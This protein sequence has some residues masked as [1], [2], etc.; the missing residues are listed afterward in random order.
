MTNTGATLEGRVVI[1]VE[2]VAKLLDVGRTS[3]Y[4][5]VKR[6]EI[7]SIKVGRR[8]LVPVAALERMLAG[9]SLVQGYDDAT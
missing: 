9:D 3:A 6:G 8:L 4:A 1:T 5:A 7:P 2:E